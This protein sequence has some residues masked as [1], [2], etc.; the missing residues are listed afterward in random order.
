MRPRAAVQNRLAALLLDVL[1]QANPAATLSLGEAAE[2]TRVAVSPAS[3]LPS[4]NRTQAL[5]TPPLKVKG[6]AAVP[7]YPVL[8]LFLAFDHLDS[9][10]HILRGHLSLLLLSLIVTVVA[11]ESAAAAA[12]PSW[13]CIA[14]LIVASPRCVLLVRATRHCYLACAAL[15]RTVP[16]VTSA[17]PW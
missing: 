7:A 5:R 6:E 3:P 16:T 12:S 11:S 17:L 9:H 10:K 13:L 2:G 8:Y 4:G 15:L 14:V 1:A